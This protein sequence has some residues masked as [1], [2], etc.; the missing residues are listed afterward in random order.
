MKWV[1]HAQVDQIQILDSHPI[2]QSSNQYALLTHTLLWYVA[3]VQ[4]RPQDPFL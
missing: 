3:M 2:F 1:K 4:P